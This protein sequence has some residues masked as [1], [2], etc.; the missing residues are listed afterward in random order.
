MIKI[1]NLKEEWVDAT[2]FGGE[3]IEIFKNISKAELKESGNA[4]RGAILKNGD[5]YIVDAHFI[6]HYSMLSIFLDK[7]ILKT[8]GENTWYSDSTSFK[9]FLAIIQEPKTYN[10]FIADSYEDELVEYIKK[11]SIFDEYKKNFESKNP[12]YTL[13]QERGDW[14]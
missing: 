9:N 5:L 10:F 6:V 4:V 7:G 12:Y 8:L 2:K 14:F 13:K 3:Y 11:D 1:R